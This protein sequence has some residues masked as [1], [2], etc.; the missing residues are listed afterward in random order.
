MC[1]NGPLA[2]YNSV[3]EQNH[4]KDYAFGNVFPLLTPQGV[5]PP[6][7]VVLK[8]TGYGTEPAEGDIGLYIESIELIRLS[9]GKTVRYCDVYGRC[10]LYYAGGG[11][12]VFTCLGGNV[13]W[14]E[15]VNHTIVYTG[16]EEGLY[17]IKVE[18]QYMASSDESDVATMYSEV[19]CM[20]SHT[21]DWLK[22]TYSSSTPFT[23]S[24]GQVRFDNDFK[25]TVY[26]DTQVGRPKYPFEEEVSE[27]MGYSF[28]ESQ[29]SKKTFGFTALA[30]EYLCDALRLV[31]LCDKRSITSRGRS[32]SPVSFDMDVSWEDQ[33][34]LASLQCSFDTDTVVCGVGGY[35]PE[36]ALRRMGFTN[37]FNLDFD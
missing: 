5:L 16:P 10:K 36:S 20:S 11:Y 6:F 12:A 4:R 27:R 9:D 24:R 23:L 26:L 1:S 22:L 18:T 32:Y 3:G 34:D 29:V 30:P 13:Q 14:Y 8:L 33:G 28:I 25:F 35:V 17:Y 31:R 37:D 19:F 21:E 7:Q 15:S 2:F